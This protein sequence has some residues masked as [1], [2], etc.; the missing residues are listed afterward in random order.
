MFDHSG[1]AIL[2]SDS[3]ISAA[4]VQHE[5][6]K[7]LY[8]AGR[9]LKDVETRYQ[10]IEKAVLVVIYHARML[11]PYFQSHP[12]IVKINCPIGKVFLKPELAGCIISWSVELSEFGLT[13][14]PRGPIKA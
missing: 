8:F 4:L 5:G 1:N 7:P 10:V 9:A 6:Q 14:E 13:F 12:I 3:A 11:R 2:V